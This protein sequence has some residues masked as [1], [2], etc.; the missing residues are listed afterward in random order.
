MKKL[1]GDVYYEK[2]PSDKQLSAIS[3]GENI[4]ADICI[5]LPFLMF[6]LGWVGC[7]LPENLHVYLRIVCTLETGC[8]SDAS[9]VTGECLLEGLYLS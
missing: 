2:M 7:L 3:S 5:G 1:K 6:P 9:Q 8:E 4:G